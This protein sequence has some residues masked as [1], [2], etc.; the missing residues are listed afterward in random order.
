MSRKVATTESDSPT[1]K[2]QKVLAEH[3]LGSRRQMESWIVAGRIK[4][5]GEVAHAGQRV[6]RSAQIEVDGKRIRRV[7]SDPSIRILV[8]NKKIGEIV[9]RRD[10]ERRK[11]V[12][13]HLPKL[14]Q[15]RWISIGRL[16]INT[17]GLLLFTNNGNAAHKLMHPS[18]IIDREYAVRVIGELSDRQVDTLKNGVQIDSSLCRFTDIRHYGGSGLNHW[19]HVVLMEGRNR[20]IRQMFERVGTKVSRLKR[21]RFGPVVL[22]A[23]MPTGHFREMNLDDV[24]AICGWLSLPIASNVS[25]DTAKQQTESMLIPFPGLELP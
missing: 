6:D 17:T 13:S 23:A 15:G 5:D 8:M 19:Y 14:N 25:G 16:D 2:L 12:F 4:V 11:T 24:R 21:V 10:P 20:E 3:G 18:T 22:P 1:Y 9:S 7:D